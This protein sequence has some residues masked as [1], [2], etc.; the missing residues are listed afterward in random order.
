MAIT[1]PTITDIRSGIPTLPASRPILPN[2]EENTSL[3]FQKKCAEG[4]ERASESKILAYPQGASK[5]S[6]GI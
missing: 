2:E 1:P 3:F 4:D 6:K 5:I